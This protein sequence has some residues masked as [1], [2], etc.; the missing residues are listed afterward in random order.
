MESHSVLGT[1]WAGLGMGSYYMA[2]IWINMLLGVFL[3]PLFLIPT[4]WLLDRHYRRRDE[5]A[6]TATTARDPYAAEVRSR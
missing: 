3:T 1:L 2:L 5:R 4:T 6:G